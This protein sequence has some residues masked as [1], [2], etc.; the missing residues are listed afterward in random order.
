MA[1]ISI[2]HPKQWTPEV[3]SN[4]NFSLHCPVIILRNAFISLH[5]AGVRVNLLAPQTTPGD[6][7]YRS[8]AA[9][10][11][12]DSKVFKSGYISLFFIVWFVSRIVRFQ[13]HRLIAPRT[14]WAGDLSPGLD[15]RA[16][17]LGSR[18]P[19]DMMKDILVLS[20]HQKKSPNSLFGR[21]KWKGD[22]GRTRMYI[23]G[24]PISLVCLHCW[25]RI[26]FSRDF[27]IP[28]QWDN[29]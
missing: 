15:H 22:I 27:Y 7:S 18:N 5:N 1:N 20:T 28:L 3:V 19:F 23:S 21:R 4:S 26:S 6:Q 29:S 8:L 16:I 2:F 12:V 14:F 11:W 10:I 25:S 13:N 17:P 24:V 9:L